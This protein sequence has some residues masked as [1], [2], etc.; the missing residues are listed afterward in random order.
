[1]PSGPTLRAEPIETPAGAA[2]DPTQALVEIELPEPGLIQLDGAPMGRFSQR[3]L[4][5]APGR[6][7]LEIASDRGNAVLEL[8]LGAGRS[9]R[10]VPG[11]G[12]APASSA[13]PSS[14]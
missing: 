9:I 4:L 5:L 12:P 10:V 2:L 11:D 1:V 7:H 13:R 14:E 6:H 3:R 8:E